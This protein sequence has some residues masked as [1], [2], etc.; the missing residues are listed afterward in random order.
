M[1]CDLC[2]KEENLVKAIVEGTELSVCNNCSSF[3]RVLKQ[4][5]QKNVNVHIPKTHIPTNKQNR[6]IIGE[7]TVFVEFIKEDIGQLI[8]RKR[9]K[10]GLKQEDFAK[11]MAVKESV[12]HNIESGHFKPSIGMAKKIGRFLRIE[13]IEKIK[14]EKIERTKNSF[15]ER[16][17]TL[18]DMIEMKMR[19][20]K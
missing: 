13:L 10:L 8:Q 3:G 1:R 14:D 18:G 11:K 4:A 7:I 19:Q 20:K 6:E 16:K 17:M 5:P 15:E 9:E 12:I 2:G